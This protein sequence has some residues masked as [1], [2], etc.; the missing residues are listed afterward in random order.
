MIWTPL[1]ALPWSESPSFAIDLRSYWGIKTTLNAD[2]L[3]LSAESDRAKLSAHG[4]TLFSGAF[5]FFQKGG[6][7]FR[8]Q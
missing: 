1:A 2:H 5:A 6:R 8:I 4:A 7:H 3:S